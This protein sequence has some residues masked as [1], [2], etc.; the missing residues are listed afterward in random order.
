MRKNIIFAYTTIS[1]LLI[2]GTF[3]FNSAIG[4]GPGTL[5]QENLNIPGS[6]GSLGI[7][8]SASFELGQQ[9]MQTGSDLHSVDLFFHNSP[10]AVAKVTPVKVCIYQSLSLNFKT[11]VLLDCVTRNITEGPAVTDVD[12]I[13]PGTTFVE[14]FEF[15]PNISQTPGVTYV[16]NVEEDRIP[17]NSDT[18]IFWLVGQSYNP[19]AAVPDEVG[20]INGVPFAGPVSNDLA[21]RT[22]NE[23]GAPIQIICPDGTAVCSIFTD[24]MAW[25][26]HQLVGGIFTT[27]DFTPPAQPGFVGFTSD[28]GELL[29]D[30]ID[31][32]IFSDVLQPGGNPTI[33]NFVPGLDA[34]GSDFDLQFPGEPGIGISVELMDGTILNVGEIPNTTQGFWGV[35]IDKPFKS[36][37]LENVPDSS[38]EEIVDVTNVES[39]QQTYTLDNMVFSHK[40]FVGGELIPLDTTSLLLGYT[41]LNSYWIAPTAVGIGVGIYL[42]KRRF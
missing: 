17:A 1:I 35:T 27:E 3:L 39:G 42:V 37:H 7:A 2:S 18:Q 13:S 33:F 41:T 24:K 14:N 12:P 26:N 5:D 34:W 28:N 23:Q 31:G 8:S 16:I 22:Y 20:I 11:G 9:Y 36:V 10:I 38:T 29:V 4:F 21:F 32:G 30:V 19:G 15:S 6:A 40:N 25:G